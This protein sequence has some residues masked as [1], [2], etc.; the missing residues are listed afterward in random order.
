MEKKN[1]KKRSPT[2]RRDDEEGVDDPE[3][4]EEEDPMEYLGLV[5]SALFETRRILEDIDEHGQLFLQIWEIFNIFCGK[6]LNVDDNESLGSLSSRSEK[7][8]A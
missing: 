6:L 2:K 1:T 8:A 4:S 5:K 3:E 7:T